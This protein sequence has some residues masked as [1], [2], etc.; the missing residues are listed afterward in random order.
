VADGLPERQA[1]PGQLDGARRASPGPS[2]TAAHRMRDVVD[3]RRHVC[4]GADGGIPK[5]SPR[6]PRLRSR[7]TPSGQRLVVV[8]GH[9]TSGRGLL[10]V[11][12]GR[13]GARPRVAVCNRRRDDADHPFVGETHFSKIRIGSTRGKAARPRVVSMGRH[14]SQDA[15]RVT[16]ARIERRT[17]EQRHDVIMGSAASRRRRGSITCIC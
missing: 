14:G 7:H 5:S 12:S 13:A 10:R 16:G 3:A 6:S 9:V 4:A 8:R 15:R 11:G 2:P 17:G 1:A